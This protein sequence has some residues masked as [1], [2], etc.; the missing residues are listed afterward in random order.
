MDRAFWK[1]IFELNE[2]RYPMLYNAE[3][4]YARDPC[5]QRGD[6][7]NYCQIFR[8]ADLTTLLN[9]IEAVSVFGRGYVGTANGRPVRQMHGILSLSSSVID[10]SKV[11]FFWLRPPFA[12]EPGDFIAECTMLYDLRD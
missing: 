9:E 7:I 12:I 10:Y 1:M 5:V 3:H 8:Q 2:T 6:K 11:I 4:V